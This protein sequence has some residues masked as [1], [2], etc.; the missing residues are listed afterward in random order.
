MQHTLTNSVHYLSQLDFFETHLYEN[1]VDYKERKSKGE[2]TLK[3]W[4]SEE[5]WGFFVGD[6]EDTLDSAKK[7]M[8]AEKAKNAKDSNMK[9]VNEEEG[10]DDGPGSISTPSG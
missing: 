2:T 8:D 1:Y 5:I 4:A 7:L 6:V 10:G 9:E 3:W